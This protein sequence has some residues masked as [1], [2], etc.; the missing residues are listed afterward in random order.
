MHATGGQGGTGGA[1][2]A[3]G[4]AGSRGAGGT[5]AGGGSGQ[6]G[7]AGSAGGMTGA[8]GGTTGGAGQGGAGGGAPGPCAG[9]CSNPVVFSTAGYQSGDLGT[10][11][12]CHQTTSDIQ[13]IA[14]GNFVTP[15]TLTVNGKPIPC[16]G[17]GTSALPAKISGGY[18]IQA[19]AGDYS[20]AYFGTY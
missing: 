13:G 11:V 16:T 12:T 19:T 2:G 15:R 6:G 10:K 20:F 1:A 9:L 5:A 17:T 4:E 7:Q 3:G 18:C 8:A 14:C